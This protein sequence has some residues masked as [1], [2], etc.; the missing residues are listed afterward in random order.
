MGGILNNRGTTLVETLIIIIL[1]GIVSRV[2]IPNFKKYR[3]SFKKYS[4]KKDCLKVEYPSEICTKILNEKG[5][6]KISSNG[7][8]YK[9]SRDE[10]GYEAGREIKRSNVVNCQDK[11]EG[12]KNCKKGKYVCYSNIITL[13][14]ICNFEH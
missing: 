5:F 12:F 10:I 14:E 13:E 2:V 9:Y 6:D 3:L 11:G 8:I 1:I 4:I 7:L